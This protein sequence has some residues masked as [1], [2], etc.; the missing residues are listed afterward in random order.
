MFEKVRY[1]SLKNYRLC[2]C[3]YL[4]T[5]ALNWDAIFSLTKVELELIS[6]LGTYLFF[7]KSMKDRLSYISKRYSKT[8]N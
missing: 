2:P 3:N 7:E 8:S 5:P 1:S 4:R 6:N